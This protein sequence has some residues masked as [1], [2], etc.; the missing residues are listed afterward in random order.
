MAKEMVTKEVTTT[1]AERKK[2]E[3]GGSVNKRWKTTAKQ[4]W[5]NVDG[6]GS[7]KKREKTTKKT[8]KMFMV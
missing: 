6:G 5:K 8:R 2:V 1:K 4:A 3:G 7:V